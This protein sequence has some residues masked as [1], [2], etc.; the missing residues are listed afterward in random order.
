MFFKFLQGFSRDFKVLQFDKAHCCP[1]DLAQQPKS[2]NILL[3]LSFLRG[4]FL[5][6]GRGCSPLERKKIT[7]GMAS[8]DDDDDDDDH[9]NMLR[10]CREKRE[11]EMNSTVL[12]HILFKA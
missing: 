8:V 1:P 12:C 7:T 10:C 5:T 9:K 6:S 11:N 4:Y 3:H 2:K